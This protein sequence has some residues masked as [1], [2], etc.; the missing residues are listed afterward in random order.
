[1]SCCFAHAG[2]SVSWERAEAEIKKDDPK[3]IEVIK[4]VFIMNHVGGALRLGKYSYEAQKDGGES[5]GKRVPPYYFYCKLKDK[6]GDF[7]LHMTLNYSDSGSGW[8]FTIR[9]KT[10]TD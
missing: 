4:S 6:I 10:E 2:G 9:K 1:V 8:S 3:I 7:D 5:I